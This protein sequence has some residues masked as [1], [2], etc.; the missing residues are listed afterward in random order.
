MEVY[1]AC[2]IWDVNVFVVSGFVTGG[3]VITAWLAKEEVNNLKRL[4]KY[5]PIYTKNE[6]CLS[7][8]FYGSSSMYKESLFSLT[9]RHKKVSISSQV[10]D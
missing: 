4:I 1:Q 9:I 5:F 7:F 10:N 2:G 3:M 8:W 6:H